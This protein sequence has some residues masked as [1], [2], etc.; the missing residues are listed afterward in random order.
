MLKTM[1]AEEFNTATTPRHPRVA[2]AVGA[3][4]STVRARGPWSIVVSVI[5]AVIV[6]FGVT[7]PNGNAHAL[8]LSGAFKQC[9]DL[10]NS[11]RPLTSV[12]S[13]TMKMISL[14]GTGQTPDSAYGIAGAKYSWYV[15][16]GSDNYG[17]RVGK[18]TLSPAPDFNSDSSDSPTGKCVGLFEQVSTSFGTGVN[19]FLFSI[20]TLVYQVTAW[21]F[22]NAYS[23]LSL[24]HI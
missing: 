21:V 4:T 13:G 8:D 5:L 17:D 19:N 20:T 11:G 24:I 3:V 1:T 22:Q 2:N 16:E 6:I 18:S 7:V 15:N 23:N 10:T 12:D 14:N 9:G